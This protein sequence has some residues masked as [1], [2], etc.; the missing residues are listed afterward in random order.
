MGT[1]RKPHSLRIVRGDTVQVIAGDDKGKVGRV[2]RVLSEKGRV[3]VEGVNLVHRHIRR[4]QQ[5]PQGGRVRREAAIHLSNVMVIDP[6]SEAPTK[7]GRKHSEPEK[8]S[9]G[10]VRVARKSGAVIGQGAAKPTK[11]GKKSKE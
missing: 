4:S 5:N 6:E 3:V 10:W 1:A 11:K 7:V 2:L 8:G 9:L